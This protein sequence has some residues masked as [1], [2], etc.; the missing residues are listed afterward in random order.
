MKYLKTFKTHEDYTNFLIEDFL[1]GGGDFPQVALCLDKD[2]KNYNWSNPLDKN[3]A[4]VY[5]TTDKKALKLH[6]E[7]I[8]DTELI[9]NV[10]IEEEGQGYLFFKERPTALKEGCFANG[11]WTMNPDDEWVLYEEEPNLETMT[12]L[13]EFKEIPAFAFAQ[14]TNLSLL[15]LADDRTVSIETFG[16]CAFYNC[17]NASF[18]F[19]TTDLKIT[20]IG[21]FSFYGCKG[22]HGMGVNPDY[23]GD[24]VKTIGKQAFAE[25]GL[26]QI[27][28]DKITSLG[29]GAFYCADNFMNGALFEDGYVIQCDIPDACFEHCPIGLEILFYGNKIGNNAFYDTP[30]TLYALSESVITIEG[31]DTLNH[32][33]TLYVPSALLDAYKTVYFKY[34]YLIK[35]NPYEGLTME[36][37]TER[38]SAADD[39]STTEAPSA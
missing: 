32:L 13:E 26:Y 10:F 30:V 16:D 34:A 33:Q 8:A 31:E 7:D 22:I 35:E 24:N 14:Q 36:E 9:A 11:T 39:S 4:I 28:T 5:T 27:Q 23:F 12:L 17:A 38:R 2:H 1:Q 3:K 15:L 21:D 29:E 20:S 25:S 6:T 37:I 18:D 19:R